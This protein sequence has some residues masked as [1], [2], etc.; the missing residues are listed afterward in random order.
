MLLVYFR[1]SVLINYFNCQYAEI[2]NDIEIPSGKKKNLSNTERWAIY[3]ALLERSHDGNLKKNTTRE[4]SELFL[5]S[6]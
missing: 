3:N 2:Y 6:I 5:V 1:F 4:V